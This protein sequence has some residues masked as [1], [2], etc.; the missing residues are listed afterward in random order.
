MKRVATLILAV[1]PMAALAQTPATTVTEKVEVVEK[2]TTV[3]V[4]AE[5]KP[6]IAFAPYGFVLLTGFASDTPFS[7][8]LYPAQALPCPGSGCNL[9]GSFNMSAQQSR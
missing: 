6:P 1:L 8:R 5:K 7:S 4:V 2:T 9:G 3:A